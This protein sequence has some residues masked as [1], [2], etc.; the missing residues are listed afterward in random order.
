M[1]PRLALSLVL[2]ALVNACGSDHDHNATDAAADHVHSETDVVTDA[3][4]VDQPAVD[5][6][7]DVAGDAASVPL[8][9]DCRAAD[10]EDRSGG[11][12]T[13]R[14]V[15]PRGT[16]GYTPRCFTIRAGQ[17]VTF[18][19]DFMTHPLV[20]GVPHGSSAGA[21]TPSPIQNQSTGT[22]YTVMFASA[23]YYPFYCTVHGHAGMAGVVRVQ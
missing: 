18:E 22:M 8:L 11:A 19:M 23:G 20:S 12:D 3:A 2:A 10:Y 14:V 16:T 7:N 9:N 6:A 21:T 4:T 13:T 1:H 15:R 5:V 17:P